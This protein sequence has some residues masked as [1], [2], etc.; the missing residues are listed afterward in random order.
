VGLGNPGPEYDDTRH[1][2]GFRLADRLV[3]R[4]QLGPFRRGDRAREARGTW[5][6]HAVSVLKPQTYMNRSG[7]ALA[8]LRSLPDFDPSRDLLILVDDVAL[9]LGRFRL[10]GA[11]SAG[12]HNGLRSVEGALQ[13]QDYARLRIGVGPAPPE[14]DD[15]ADYVLDRFSQ[16]ELAM[17]T[18]LLDP[19]S[20]A[21]ECWLEDGIETAM[22]RF[23]R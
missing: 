12:G 2:A 21:V 5:Q 18:E 17:L 10:R 20:E 3:D 8:P 15:L 4:W 16:E 13:R 6:N 11:G 23:N 9:P 19:M 14:L 22:N 1:N 7:A